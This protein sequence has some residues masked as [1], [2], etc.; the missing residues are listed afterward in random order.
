MI[1]SGRRDTLIAFER[2]S[3]SE[4][5]DGDEIQDWAE[6][7]KEWAAVNWGRGDERRQAA[8]E[9]AEQPAT[10]TVLD[11]ELTRSLTTSNRIQAD[12]IWDITS[13]VPG[14]TRGERDITAI[15]SA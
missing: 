4:N 7:G 8:M 1:S 6:I 12:G 2:A 3:V 9:R 15:R 14:K 13:T 5:E 10:F 11:N